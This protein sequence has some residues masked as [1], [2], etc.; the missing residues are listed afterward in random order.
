MPCYSLGVVC[1]G[2]FPQ[3]MSFPLLELRTGLNSARVNEISVSC[4]IN[5]STTTL[6]IGTPAARGVLGAAGARSL[7]PDNTLDP[8]SKSVAAIEWSQFPTQ[9]TKYLRRVYMPTAAPQGM[10]LAFPRGLGIGPNA[11]LTINAVSIVGSAVDSYE[12]FTSVD[13]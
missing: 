9:P 11:S 12:I 5:G 6:G 4:P 13:E 8:P 10:L 7:V 3:A 2:L 1:A